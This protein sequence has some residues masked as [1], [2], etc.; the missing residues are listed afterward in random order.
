MVEI[1]R[2]ICGNGNCFLIKDNDEAILVDTSRTKYRKQ[3]IDSCK[4]LNIKL[5]ILTHGHVDH[6][7][8]AAYLSKELNAPIAM[9]KADYELSKNNIPEPLSAHTLLGKIILAL[10]I[11]SFEKDEIESI[12]PTIFLSYGDSLNDFGI[13]ATII[14]LPGHTKGSIGI[15]V[16][17]NDFIVGDALMNM[18]YPTTSLLYGNYE[19]MKNSADRISNSGQMTIHFGHGKSVSNRKW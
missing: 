10:S 14:G 18:F 16:G 13:N 6:I 1:K 8:N 9:H 5:I 3:I 7:Q 19:K 11:K 17:E 4:N 15:K 2:I 12:E